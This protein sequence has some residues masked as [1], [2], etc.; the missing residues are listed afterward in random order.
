MMALMMKY[1]NP[2]RITSFTIAITMFMRSVRLVSVDGLA[3]GEGPA[4]EIVVVDGSV[5]AVV[6]GT[7]VVDII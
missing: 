7:S 4:A 5:A 6:D 3:V 2:I 1:R